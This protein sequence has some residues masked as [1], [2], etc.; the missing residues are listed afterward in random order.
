MPAIATSTQCGTIGAGEGI[1]PGQSIVSCDGG[2][3]LDLQLD[4]NLV[5]YKG[6]KS[7]W[8]PS[9]WTYNSGAGELRLEADGNLVVYS[10]LGTKIWQSGSGGHDAARLFVQGDGNTV[11]YDNNGPIWNTGTAGQ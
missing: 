7:I 1:K 11:I 2:Y 10:S 8:L 3:H 5:L 4:S 6:D 9:P